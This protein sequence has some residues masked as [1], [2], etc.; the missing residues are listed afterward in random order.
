MVG[1]T[2]F[3]NKSTKKML[4]RIVEFYEK[5][6]KEKPSSIIDKEKE[7]CKELLSYI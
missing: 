2:I 6:I 5:E 4:E 3:I 1:D 7:D